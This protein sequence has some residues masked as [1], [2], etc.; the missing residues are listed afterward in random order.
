MFGSALLDVLSVISKQEI[1]THT[2]TNLAYNKITLSETDSVIC[3]ETSDV[4]VD[5]DLHEVGLKNVTHGPYG[6]LNPN[7]SYMT[8][9]K[10][11]E[12]YTSAL[13]SNTVTRND[14]YLYNCE[15]VALK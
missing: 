3:A 8:E 13:V 14:G 9:G 4:H 15:T 6:T 1:V 7:S 11:Y 5:K 10:C 2:Y 12:R